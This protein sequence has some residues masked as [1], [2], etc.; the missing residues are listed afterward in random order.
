MRDPE[1]LAGEIL[2][3]NLNIKK[4]L[5]GT[6]TLSTLIRLKDEAFDRKFELTFL[7]Y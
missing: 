1:I 5:E 2:P 6:S 3:K 4:N 7:S